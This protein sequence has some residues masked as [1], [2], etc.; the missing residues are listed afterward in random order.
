MQQTDIHTFDTV[1][2]IHFVG[3]KGIAM[4]AL[5]VWGK[6]RGMKV[7][8]SDT[9]EIFP[10]DEILQ[11]VGILV[12]S[13]FSKEH[14]L[15]DHKPDLVIY[16]G[17]HGGRENIEVITAMSLGIPVLPHGKALGIAMKGKRQISVAGS[18]GKTTTSSMIATILTDAGAAPSYAIGCGEIRGLGLPGHSGIGDYFVAEADEYVTDPTHDQT[19]RFLWQHPD[20]LVVTNIDYDHPDAYASLSKVQDAFITFQKQQSGRAVTIINSDD[21]AS[22]PMMAYKGNTIIT[23]GTHSDAMFRM[24]DISYPTERAVFLL[25]YK[26]EQC[27]V[28]TLKVPGIHNVYNATAAAISC[29]VAGLGWDRIADG[30][31]RF[32]G[33]KR[34]FEK[35]ASRDGVTFYDDYAHHPKEIQATLAAAKL[36]YPHSRIISVFQPHT[37][38]RTKKLLHDFAISFGN[39]DIVAITDIFASAREKDTLGITSR[40]LIAEIKK[41]H[42]KV[43]YTPGRDEIIEYLAR[44]SKKGDVVFFIGAGDIF[45]WE[46]TIIDQLFT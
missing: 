45:S 44:V 42:K 33:A 21:P 6:E 34:R 22:Q 15:K 41:Y 35:I 39:A 12:S 28:F 29:H 37:Y 7:T 31:A 32:E 26:G 27:G 4:T 8:G 46:K 36:W 23:Y 18:H 10:S 3:I 20:I 11:K 25:S 1:H 9:D 43:E 30:L 19:P 14:I 5:A 17:A 24:T 38:S 16:T 40:N 13:G 2:S